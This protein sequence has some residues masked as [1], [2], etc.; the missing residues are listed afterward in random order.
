MQLKSI[1]RTFQVDNT[2]KLTK[3]GTS[4]C[5]DQRLAFEISSNQCQKKGPVKVSIMMS[6]LADK[7]QVFQISVASF[8]VLF[9]I[10]HLMY[11]SV[12]IRLEYDSN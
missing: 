2:L 1:E 6:L 3:I 11:V 9:R 5:H 7:S 12:V 4:C 10:S 8:V